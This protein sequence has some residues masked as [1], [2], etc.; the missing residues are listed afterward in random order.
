[1]LGPRGLLAGTALAL[2]VGACGSPATSEPDGQGPERLD[3]GDSHE[4]SAAPEPSAACGAAGGLPYRIGTSVGQLEFMESV[5]TFRVHLPPGYDARA[6]LPLVLMFHGGGGGSLQFELA[7]ARMDPIADRE[8]FIAVYPDGT[9]VLKTWNGGGC[10]GYAVANDVD[11]VGFVRALLDHLE[12]V[13]CIDRRRIYA[14]GMSNG[15]I[16]TH[17]LACEVSDRIAAIAPVAGTDNSATCAPTRAVPLLTIHGSADGHVPWQGGQGCGLAGVSFRSVPD[18]MERWRTRNG[19]AGV[20]SEPYFRQ[21]EGTC[22]ATRGCDADVILCTI[23]GG[24]HNWP[25]GEPP[26]DVIDCPTDG[27]QS[28]TF[29][30][31]EVVWRFFAQQSLPMR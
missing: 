10:C 2:L 24:G 31:S 25:G 19:C 9:G 4:E 8:R 21:G 17:R 28:T 16:L 22:E 27:P 11:D 20:A 14:T 30:A 26:A 3:A 1:M 7:S 18:T 6:P 29:V 5:R 12:D 23:E 15:A 13:L